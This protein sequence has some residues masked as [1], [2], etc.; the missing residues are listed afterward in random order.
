M[1]RIIIIMMLIAP[2][3]VMAQK[4]G[5]VDSQS[6]LISL[7][8]V[9]KI[10]EE[11]EALAKKYENEITTMQNELQRKVDEFYKVES[12]MSVTDRNETGNR[13]QEMNQRIQDK[14]SQIQQDLDKKRE[15]KLA[16][17]Y[18]KV[19]TAIQNV[20]KAGHYTYIFE[21]NA[22][23]YVGTDSKDVTA[24]VKAELKKLK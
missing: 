11:M 16:V 1:K 15:E 20:G 6:L 5:H 9:L 12:T 3:T 10:N 7:P 14:A 23:L 13:L 8:E 4:L 19:K 2:M 18:D 21:Q 24:E 22:T 17:V